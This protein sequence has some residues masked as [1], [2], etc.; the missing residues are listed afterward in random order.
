MECPCTDT[1][2][3]MGQ[4]NPGTGV[5]DPVVDGQIVLVSGPFRLDVPEGEL[6]VMSERA[7]LERRRDQAGL[8]LAP[9]LLVEEGVVAAVG[10]R[11]LVEAAGVLDPVGRAGD[12]LLGP[13]VGI[14]TG[15]PAAPGSV[16]VLGIGH[17]HDRRG[18][19]RLRRGGS[20]EEREESHQNQDK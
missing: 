14:I 10:G 4:L 3:I 9:V 17:R 16:E 11:V 19:R 2:G 15:R 7:E 6:G 12:K 18:R 1:V 8:R 13:D 5:R 20:R